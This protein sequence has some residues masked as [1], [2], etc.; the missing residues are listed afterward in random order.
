MKACGSQIMLSNTYHLLVQP[1]SEL[2]SKMGGLQEA[3]CWRGPM[4]TDSGGYQIFSM[5]HGSVSNE[6]KGRRGAQGGQMFGERG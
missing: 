5:G 6:I 4:L 2:I 3:T 1:G